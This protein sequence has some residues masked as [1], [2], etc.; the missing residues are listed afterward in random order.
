MS[1]IIL[2]TGYKSEQIEALVG[3]IYKELSVTYSRETKPLG[4]GGALCNALSLVTSPVVLVMNGDSYFDVDL[5]HY[6]NWFFEQ[7]YDASL[8]LS[9]VPDT[10]RYGRVVMD[11]SGRII[12]FDE[13]GE[14]TGAGWINAG[15]YLFHTSLLK[16]IPYGSFFSLEHTFLS[17]LIDKGVYG[18]CSDGKFIDIGTPNSYIGAVG[19][20]SEVNK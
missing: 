14:K 1:R 10:R 17:G 9:R 12:R 11:E 2:C 8:L 7:K 16:S 5:K 6:L 4:T 19:F 15:V 20:F 18:F 13:K 3:T